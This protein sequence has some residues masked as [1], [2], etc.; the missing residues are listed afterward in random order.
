M[1][2]VG[3]I[4]D[5]IDSWEDHFTGDMG[6]DWVQ[7]G[8]ELLEELRTIMDR[9]P[10]PTVGIWRRVMRG[11][12]DDV[13]HSL[14][15]DLLREGINEDWKDILYKIHGRSMGLARRISPVDHDMKLEDE[16]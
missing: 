9:V 14:V 13:Q 4:A 8:L 1:T 16:E 7:R 12:D 11:R 3:L 5:A 10:T 6:I 2:D 15:E